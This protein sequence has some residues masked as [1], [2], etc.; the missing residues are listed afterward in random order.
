M[1]DEGQYGDAL[2]AP[3]WA[4]ARRKELALQRCTACGAV[5][6]Y[7]RPFCLACQSDDVEWVPAGGGGVVYSMT[8]VRIQIAP[9]FEP[10]YIVAL[11]ELDEGPR[12][13][14]NIL[15][16]CEIGQ[17]VRLAWKDRGAVPP[18]PVFEADDGKD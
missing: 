2:T 16:A 7:P 5:Q 1:N 18:L 4:A 8:T 6:F 10:P 12:I 17:R 9:E 14:T 15:G 11:V 13:L 3:Y